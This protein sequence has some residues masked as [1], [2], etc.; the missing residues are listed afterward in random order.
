MQL[1]DRSLQQQYETYIQKSLNIFLSWICHLENVFFKAIPL[2]E[3][4]NM[5][6]TIK[7]RLYVEKTM[8]LLLCLFLNREKDENRG[9]FQNWSINFVSSVV[10]FPRLF[11]ETKRP[12]GTMAH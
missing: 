4:K 8:I 10:P 7:T 5:S 11:I 3:S 9:K 12:L 1:Q 6:S 2:M